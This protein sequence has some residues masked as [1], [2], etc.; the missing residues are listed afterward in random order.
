MAV[1]TLGAL[2]LLVPSRAGAVTV[3]GRVGTSQGIRGATREVVGSRPVCVSNR[4]TTTAVSFGLVRAA[5]RRLEISLTVRPPREIAA[6]VGCRSFAASIQVTLQRGASRSGMAVIAM[7]EVYVAVRRLH[8]GRQVLRLSLP[9]PAPAA[10]N[11]TLRLAIG[12]IACRG[13][14]IAPQTIS[15]RLRVL[16]LV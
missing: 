9:S 4:G 5:G 7:P 12:A 13:K 15:A 8:A 10:H 16:P 6:M 3:Q 1:L 2:G 11:A 14:R